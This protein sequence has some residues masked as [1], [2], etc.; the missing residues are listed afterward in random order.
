MVSTVSWSL[1]SILKLSKTKPKA[2]G[3]SS[4]LSK[5]KI[6]MVEERKERREAEEKGD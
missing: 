6:E 5:H 1:V 3:Q 2:E 4:K